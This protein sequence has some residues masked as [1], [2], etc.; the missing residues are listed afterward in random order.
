[1][2]SLIS[3]IIFVHF[4]IEALVTIPVQLKVERLACS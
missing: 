2:L 3:I 4:F 1:M